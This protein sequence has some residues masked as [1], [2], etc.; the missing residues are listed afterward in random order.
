LSYINTKAVQKKVHKI[1]FP[2]ISGSDPTVYSLGDFTA[3][4]FLLK[5]AMM[6]NIGSGSF[7][8]SLGDV[9][10]LS[11][12]SFDITIS[13][14]AV[15]LK[16][17]G[18]LQASM[19]LDIDGDVSVGGDGSLSISSCNTSVKKVVNKVKGACKLKKALGDYMEQ[20]SLSAKQGQHMGCHLL[21][22]VVDQLAEK[23][24]SHLP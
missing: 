3:K 19:T 21:Q 22:D 6:S 5:S 8:L 15:P 20:S 2:V 24:K 12:G 7:K 4:K 1:N 14:R 10:F 23:F 18:K 16:L 11:F 17:A 13:T 9:A